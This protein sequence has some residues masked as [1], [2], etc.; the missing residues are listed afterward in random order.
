MSVQVQIATAYLIN[1]LGLPVSNVIMAGAMYCVYDTSNWML[2]K[3]NHGNLFRVISVFRFR[4]WYARKAESLIDFNRIVIFHRRMPNSKI[5]ETI[6]KFQYKNKK[7]H[8]EFSEKS[9][10]T[11]TLKIEKIIE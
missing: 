6:N 7:K 5:T 10:D 9:T 1:F 3:I 4:R 11:K 2:T 8:A